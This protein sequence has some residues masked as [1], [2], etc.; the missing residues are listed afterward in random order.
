[1]LRTIRTGTWNGRTASAKSC[2]AKISRTKPS[3]KFSRTTPKRFT[4]LHSDLR[5][6]KY[7][8]STIVISNDRLCGN[9][10]GT[11][12]LSS[13]RADKYLDSYEAISFVVSAVAVKDLAQV[14]Y[15]G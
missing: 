15:S 4:G 3:R 14:S 11:L 6:R 12:R 1:M 13:G 8:T 10:I 2:A 9:S 7:S 5:A